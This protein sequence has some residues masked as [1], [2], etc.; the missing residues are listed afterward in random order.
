MNQTLKEPYILI[1]SGIPCSGKSTFTNKIINDLNNRDSYGFYKAISISRDSIR[2]ELFPEKYI[3]NKENER[4][5]TYYFFNQLCLATKLNQ[6]IIIDNTN[7]KETDILKFLNNR[8]L[9]DYNKYIKF[10][11]ISLYKAY[12]RNIVRC[13]K[14][15]KWIPF[16]AI[17][18]MYYNYNKINKEKYAKYILH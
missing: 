8:L 10:F 9:E 12:W 15:D 4:E 1:L 11:D 3:Y 5:V 7:C 18:R 13:Y 14:T 6:N 16:K 17:K 2:K